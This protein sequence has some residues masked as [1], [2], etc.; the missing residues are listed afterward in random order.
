MASCPL[1]LMTGYNWLFIFIV[2]AIIDRRSF[3][4][5]DQRRNAYG[6]FQR[7]FM[8]MV[9]DELHGTN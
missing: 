9:F 5:A 6:N 8:G 1:P 3:L 4:I 7:E 2:C